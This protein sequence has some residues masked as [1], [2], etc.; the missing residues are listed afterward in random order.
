M[1][2]VEMY[3]LLLAAKRRYNH[4]LWKVS[5]FCVLRRGSFRAIE[6]W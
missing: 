4:R 1:F 2:K 6:R 3:L 5:V